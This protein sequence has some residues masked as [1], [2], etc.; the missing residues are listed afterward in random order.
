MSQPLEPRAWLRAMGNGWSRR[1]PRCGHGALFERWNQVRERCS[2]C[3]LKYLLNQGDPWVF[4]LFLDRGVFILPPIAIIYF[5]LLPDSVVGIVA[6]FGAVVAALIYTTPHR[7][8]VCVALDWLT[9]A[10]DPEY[11][12]YPSGAAAAGPPSS[13]P[14]VPDASTSTPANDQDLEHDRG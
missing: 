9:R 13:D 11:P 14:P 5:G 12:G 7:Y 8:G 3:D 10:D 1:C 4:L 6:V 2:E